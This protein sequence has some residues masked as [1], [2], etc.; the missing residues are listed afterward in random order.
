M[1][2]LISVLLCVVLLFCAA[3]CSKTDSVLAGTKWDMSKQQVKAIVG[4]DK[5]QDGASENVI[6]W[7]LTKELS[8]VFG[9]RTVSVAFVFT[10]DKMSSIT[11]QIFTGDGETIETAMSATKTAM[12][13]VYGPADEGDSVHWHGETAAISLRTIDGTKSFFIASF[14]PMTA[15]SH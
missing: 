7:M 14:S 11:V 13:K 15:H 9:E 5:V 1:K 6:N 10:E 8:D 4:E 12:E 2:R 3:G